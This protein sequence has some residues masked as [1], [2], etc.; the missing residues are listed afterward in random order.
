MEPIDYSQIKASK[1]VLKLIA[2]LEDKLMLTEDALEDITRAAEIVEITG[3]REI[4]STWITQS[5]EFLKNRIVRPDSSI[6]ADQ[7]KILVVTDE[8]KDNKNVT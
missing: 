5:N 7:Q 4:L 1:K 6:S 8:T 2:E 3:Q